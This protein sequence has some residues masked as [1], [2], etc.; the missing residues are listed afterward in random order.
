MYVYICRIKRSQ[1]KTV[2]KIQEVIY[3]CLWIKFKTNFD[4]MEFTTGLV[5]HRESEYVAGVFVTLHL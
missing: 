4:D 5:P 3:E 1:V 2:T